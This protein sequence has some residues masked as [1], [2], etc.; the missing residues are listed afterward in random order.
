LIVAS[1]QANMVFTGNQAG[2]GPDVGTRAM[3]WTLLT[4]SQA[5]Y[6]AGDFVSTTARVYGKRVLP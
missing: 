4:A 6:Q 2:F 5:E 3:G 1:E